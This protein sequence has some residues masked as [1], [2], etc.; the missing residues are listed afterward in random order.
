MATVLKLQNV[1]SIFLVEVD[2]NPSIAA[3]TLPNGDS[4]PV[5][6]MAF[7][8]LA[9]VG[10]VYIK[11]AIGDQ[12]WSEVDQNNADWSLIGN[13]LTGASA[14]QTNEVFGS[15]NDFDVRY[16]RNNAELQRATLEGNLFHIN[17][18]SL[19]ANLASGDRGPLM[20]ISANN[21]AFQ[22]HVFDNGG[23]GGFP[24]MT[25]IGQVLSLVTTTLAGSANFG[26][27]SVPTD[28]IL[29]L[30]SRTVGRQVGGS[31]GTIGNAYTYTNYATIR[32]VG[33]VVTI[34]QQVAAQ[35]SEDQNAADFNASLTVNST[36]VRMTVTQ[37]IQRQMRWFNTTE[38]ILITT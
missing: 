17:Q 15:S 24:V 29:H 37:G 12:A 35:T 2:A 11:T 30:F 5:G 1:G 16:I 23:A 33:D 32:N 20:T 36:A 10:K 31:S 21:Q 9:G 13:A 3:T 26:A 6:S 34:R 22:S 28:S 4:V 7:L 27:I 14:T 19:Y 18:Y 8:D 38:K 25:R